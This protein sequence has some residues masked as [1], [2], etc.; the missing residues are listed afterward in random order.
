MN[1]KNQDKYNQDLALFIK[2]SFS[3]R[4]VL[5]KL[6]IVPAG[7]NYDVLKR[8]IKAL[9]LD[10]SHFTGRGHLKGKTHEWSKR[11]PIEEVLVE[12]YKGG[13]STHKLKGKLIKIGILKHECYCC[14]ISE[15]RGQRLSLEL[16]HK[17]GNRYDNRVENLELLCPNCHS[18]THTY[19]GK[20][21][22]RVSGV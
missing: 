5:K 2:E 6:N 7:G 9:N 16:E 8:K 1:I 12:N 18:L 15:W 19:R 13:I 22:K 21:K 4:E 17:N 20:N 10:T 11:T 14:G 3:L